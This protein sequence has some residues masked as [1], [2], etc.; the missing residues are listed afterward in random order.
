MS[1]LKAGM[2]APDFELPDQNGQLVR[3]S[4]FRGKRAVV[5]YFYPK[6]DTGGCTAQACGFRD[7]FAGFREVDAEILGISSDSSES[8]E[9]FASKFSLPF[10][11]LSD[12]GGVVR[13]LYGVKKTFG[14]IPGRTTYVIDRDGVLLHV[15]SSQSEPVR[16]I[17]EALSALKK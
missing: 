17:E 16:H 15:F 8:H 2:A 9:K 1:E 4:G 12:K 13:K 11:L 14:I 6:D 10:T 3:L 7:N 5:V